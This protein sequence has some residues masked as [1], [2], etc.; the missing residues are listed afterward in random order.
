M[1]VLLR[2]GDNRALVLLPAA[3]ARELDFPA[4]CPA[5]C[6]AAVLGNLTGTLRA[7]H[8]SAGAFSA[9]D[10]GVAILRCLLVAQRAD[11]GTVSN[12]LVSV[13]LGRIHHE[14]VVGVPHFIVVC[15]CVCRGHG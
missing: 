15:V 14:L 10:T 3:R 5:P 12:L 11:L 9:P 8:G 4:H 1:L 2:E 6:R 13:A 7:D